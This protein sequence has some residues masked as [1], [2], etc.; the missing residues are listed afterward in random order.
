VKVVMLSKRFK[1]D[2]KPTLKL[3]QLQ[4]DTKIRIEE[5]IAKGIYSF[6]EVPCC[7]CGGKDFELLSQKERYGLYMPVV[8]CRECGLVQTNPRMTQESYN[9]FYQMEYRKLYLG[10]DVP[11]DVF[12]RAEYNTGGVIFGYLTRN[13]GIE[14][15]NLFIVEV[16]CA[17]GGILQYFK[18]QGNEVYGVDLDSQ[19]IEFGKANYGLK[20]E[21]GTVDKVVQLHRNP[22]IVIYADVLE[23]IL[24]PIAELTKLRETM[25]ENSFLYIRVP[26]IKRLTT[27]YKRNF[28]RF[29]QNAH[30]Y[31]FTPVTLNNVLR[32]AGYDFVCGNEVIHSV[33]HKS[34]LT[35]GG[36]FH[37]ENDY[38]SVMNFLHRLEFTR[39]LPSLYK[40]RIVLMGV[41]IRLL[42]AAGLYDV[43]QK[44]YH[45]FIH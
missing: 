7:V 12:F 30:I 33:F 42:K 17:T 45:R 10:K 32:K 34:S 38:Q 41:V 25:K 16:G 15:T 27:S 2:G 9:E 19:Y 21:V 13:L 37:Y 5:K 43:A 3:N 14:I 22:D 36:G 20:L 4:L 31:H 40:L 28:L 35:K 39:L 24:N 23:H 1:N 26:N 18:E 29:L 6:E 44:V 8:I 11:T